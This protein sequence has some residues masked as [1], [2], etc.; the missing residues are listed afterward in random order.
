MMLLY[1]D[2]CCFNRPFDNQSQQK[3]Y[4]ET[5]AKLFIQR[6]IKDGIFHIAWSYM[7]D[8]ENTANPNIDAKQAI[9]KWESI[10]SQIVIVSQ[11]IIAC[12]KKLQE[13]GFSKKDSLHIACAIEIKAKY[14]RSVDKN[15]LKKR[16]AVNEI[17]ILNPVEFIAMEDEIYE[18]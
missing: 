3:I 5:E 8:Y 6:K 18:K 1:L 11:E 4:L 16:N 9:Q 17:I 12:A 7:L 13:N 10:A 14:F 15:I 2:M